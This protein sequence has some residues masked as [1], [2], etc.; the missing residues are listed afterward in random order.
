MA[1]ISNLFE[2]PSGLT[3]PLIW[4]W[5][6]GCTVLGETE[7]NKELLPM[8]SQDQLLHSLIVWKCEVWLEPCTDKEEWR[9]LG[10]MKLPA[11]RVEGS[12][13]WCQFC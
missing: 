13:F 1:K 7:D 4:Y 9:R 11:K 3:V 2:G 12:N 5:Q 10:G 8:D 6:A